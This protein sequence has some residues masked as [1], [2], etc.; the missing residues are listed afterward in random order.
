MRFTVKIHPC[1]E[2]V[3]ALT[4]LAQDVTAS[5]RLG[6]QARML[7]DQ[8]FDMHYAERLAEGDRGSD[9]AGRELIHRL[10]SY[11]VQR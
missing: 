4:S 7:F 3:D 11:G 1:P 2:T 8:R 6:Y 5:T 9:T 10:R